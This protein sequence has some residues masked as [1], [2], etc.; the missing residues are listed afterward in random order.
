[1]SLEE[2]NVAAPAGQETAPTP[3]PSTDLATRFEGFIDLDAPELETATQEDGSEVTEED[4][5]EDKEPEEADPWAGY[6]DF[7]FD[8]EIVKIPSKLKDGYLRTAD[9]TRKTQEV[10]ETRKQLQA[11]EQELN[12]RF[13][14]TEEEYNAHLELSQIS[15]HLKQVEGIDWAA[16]YQ[17]I[18][19]DP[20][21]IDDPLAQQAEVNK[22]QAIYM[23]AQNLTAKQQALLQQTTEAAQRRTEAAQQDTAKR[24]AATTEF[25]VKNI[26]GWTPDL[27]A[28]IT[29]FAVKDLG[30]DVDTL[31]GS[32]TPQIYKTL[33]LA[34]LGQQTQIR[35]QTAKPTQASA[36]VS[37]TRTV[38]AKA[39]PQ[40]TKAP[41]DMSESEYFAYREAQIAR[42][43]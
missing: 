24:L 30:F 42:R 34:Y 35:Q 31:K 14:Q 2:M 25:A 8:G 15:K 12:Q 6:E 37:A 16:E 39:N 26:K 22:F 17:K 13:Q 33:H 11:R 7:D 18:L 1:M 41:E 27:D 10:A 36:Q 9:Y 4:A 21:L 43:K 3:E 23:Q 29:E 28:K 32:Y 40:A 38:T 19:S 20:A 5:P